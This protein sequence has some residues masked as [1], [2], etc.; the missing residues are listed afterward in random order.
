[1]SGG[2]MRPGWR[3]PVDQGMPEWVDG[4]VSLDDEKSRSEIETWHRYWGTTGPISV[5]FFPGEPAPGIAS[6]KRVERDREIIE[7][8]TGALDRQVIDNAVTYSM[9]EYAIYHVRD[10][11][12]W[13]FYRDRTTPGEPWSAERLDEVCRRFDGRRRPLSVGVGGT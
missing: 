13:E 11:K 1:M 7:H 12:S 2:L 10:R 4:C 8:E 3:R 9:P 6:E 5:D